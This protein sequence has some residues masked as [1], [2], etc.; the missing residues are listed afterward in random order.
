MSG[1]ATTETHGAEHLTRAERDRAAIIRAAHRLIGRYG[2]V[3][4]IEDILLS[5]KVNR[6]TF[7]RH[8]PS[9]DALVLA[10]QREAGELVRDR[11][12]AAVNGAVDGRAAVVAWIEE[13]LTIGWDDRRIRESRTFVAAEVGLVAGI[14][15]ALEE[16]H[17]CHRAIL[18]DAVRRAGRDGSL[19]DAQPARDAFAIHAVVQRCVEMRARGWLPRSY[20]AVVKDVLGIFVPSAVSRGE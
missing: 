20:G 19:P 14:S 5:A 11:L 7:Y 8:F 9:K 10:M 1:A 6:R 4:S 16:I 3:T 17:S 18:A 12:R 13:F 2:R 15:D